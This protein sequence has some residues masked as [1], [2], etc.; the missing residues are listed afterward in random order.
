LNYQPSAAN[1]KVVGGVGLQTCPRAGFLDL[2]SETSL[3]GW[4]ETLFYCKNHER[5]LPSFVGQLPEFQGTWNEEPTPLEVP[6]VAALTNKVN[7]WKEKGLL[8]VCMAA[9][10][11]AHRVQPLKKQV[12]LGWEYKR[13]QDLTQETQANITPELLVKHL[14]ELFQDTSSWPTNEHVRS[15]HIGIEINPVRC[16]MYFSL[17]CSL[18]F[19]VLIVQMQ[20]L[21]SFILPI[22]GSEDDISIPAMPMSTRNPGIM[23]QF[24]CFKD[25][26][27][28]AKSAYR[29]KSSKKG[30]ESL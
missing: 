26:G 12:H 28:Q 22:P 25:A 5:S 16:P 8:G 1:R 11:I 14:G 13:L 17:H 19:H 18:Q 24:Q 2:P 9:C 6:L 29:P 10:W 21:D 30:Q 20:D 27:Q 3:L 23:C 4:H 15:Y 7:L